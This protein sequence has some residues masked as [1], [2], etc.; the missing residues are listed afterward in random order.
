MLQRPAF[1]LG[2]LGL[3]PAF[4]AVGATLVGGQPL[5]EFAFRA[6]ALYAGLI[7]SFL[8]GAWWGL[9]S[10]ARERAW[11]L[12]SIA[13]VPSLAALALLL[14]MD[15]ALVILMGV[16]IL[17][18]LPVD[19]TLGGFGLTPANWMRLRVPLSVGL[20][21][22]TILLGILALPRCEGCGG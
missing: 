20:G 3:L 21:A 4:A 1:V 8:G 10:R 22:A 16:L 11:L 5:R 15:A 9:A 2:W 6:G 14:L 7:L 19:R 18:T 13:V 17:M 12:Y